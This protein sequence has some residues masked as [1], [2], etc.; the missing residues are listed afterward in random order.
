MLPSEKKLNEILS[1]L[2][3]G[4][5]PAAYDSVTD[6]VYDANNNMTSCK[7]RTGGLTGTIVATLTMTYDANNNMLTA[8]RS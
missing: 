7:Y 8:V 3:G 6:A 4:L 2:T 5:T 1:A